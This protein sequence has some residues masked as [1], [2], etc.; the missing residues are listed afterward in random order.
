MTPMWMVLAALFEAHSSSNSGLVTASTLGAL[1]KVL[2]STL[3][4]FYHGNAHLS[5]ERT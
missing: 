4:G 2:E 3:L 5:Q 1:A